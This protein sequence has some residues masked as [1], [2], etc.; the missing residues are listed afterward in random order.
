MSERLAD[1]HAFDAVEFD[2]FFPRGMKQIPAQL[3]IHPDI[4]RGAEEFG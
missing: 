2:R 4:G 1:F 3:Q